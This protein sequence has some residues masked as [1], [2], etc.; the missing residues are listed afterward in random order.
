LRS[1]LNES[2]QI[3]KFAA[4]ALFLT[5]AAF[6]RIDKIKELAP[7]EAN[8]EKAVQ[9]AFRKEGKLFLGKL[10][11]LRGFFPVEEAEEE[12]L[13]AAW[14][15]TLPADQLRQPSK[16]TYE[17]LFAGIDIDDEAIKEALRSR[18][19]TTGRWYWRC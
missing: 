7:I 11:S 19:G 4:E 2:L 12:K 16:M 17:E 10:E 3:A 1:I 18:P 6:K 13:L 5:E 8:L 14:F 15:R 9:K